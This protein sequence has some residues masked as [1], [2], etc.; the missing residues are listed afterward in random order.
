MHILVKNTM[1]LKNK[2]DKREKKIKKRKKEK[3]RN[4]THT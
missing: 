1:F 4:I 2:S 3:K